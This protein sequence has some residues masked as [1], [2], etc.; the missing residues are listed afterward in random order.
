MENKPYKL[1][2]FTD[3]QINNVYNKI[4]D[5]ENERSLFHYIF[6]VVEKEHGIDKNG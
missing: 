5:T 6:H 3:E 1:I 2:P 4:F